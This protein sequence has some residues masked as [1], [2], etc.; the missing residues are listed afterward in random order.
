MKT[1]VISSVILVATVVVA[2]LAINRDSDN[3]V[4]RGLER[5]SE[6]DLTVPETY[7]HDMYM[8]QALKRLDTLKAFPWSDMEVY[9]FDEVYKEN[10]DRASDNIKPGE[11]YTVRI[12]QFPYD[13]SP[14]QILEE[15]KR[16]GGFPVNGQGLMLVA[17]HAA[18]H[19]PD[20]FLVSLDE[21]D[22]LPVD[23]V[24]L[25]VVPE[26]LMQS[27]SLQTIDVLGRF[28]EGYDP[29]IRSQDGTASRWVM[30]FF[31]YGSSSDLL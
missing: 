28:H 30:A 26:I 8:E 6:F 31:P 16:V 22:A 20:G 12:F 3:S 14:A 18:R 10:F 7:D 25:P 15:V 4:F 11:T 17:E 9:V 29:H 21:P 19:L 1:K 24:G 23:S 27:G 2:V 13:V 5:V